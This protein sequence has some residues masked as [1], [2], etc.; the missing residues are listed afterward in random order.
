MFFSS[1]LGPSGVGL[2]SE[3]LFRTELLRERAL[4]RRGDA[5]A[6]VSAAVAAITH[7]LAPERRHSEGFVRTCC[8]NEPS[9][10]K[11]APQRELRTHLLRKRAFGRQNGATAR[12]TYALAAETS[13]RAPKRRHS[14]ECVRTCCGN[15]PCG[16][17]LTPQRRFPQQ[18]LPKPA[19]WRH[20][21]SRRENR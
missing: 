10:A 19:L 5:T 17:R 18:L 1:T 12:A 6:G 2:T 7:P 3:G 4:W 14:G 21:L 8:G 11:T 9:G 16:A 20:P 13:L 15:R